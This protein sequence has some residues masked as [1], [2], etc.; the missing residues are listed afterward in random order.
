MIVGT[1]MSLRQ[2]VPDRQ[3]LNG[4]WALIY[5]VLVSFLKYTTGKN[6]KTSLLLIKNR[7]S[8]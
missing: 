1:R 8:V 2:S 7:K 6:Y 3:E 5:C 4:N